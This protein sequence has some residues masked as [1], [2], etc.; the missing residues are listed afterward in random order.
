[1]NE[2]S[3]LNATGSFTDNPGAGSGNWNVRVT[4]GDN[5]GQ[6]NLPP[7]SSPGS[8]TLNHVYRDNGVYTVTVT[9]QDPNFL[10]SEPVSTQV[11]VNNVAPAINLQATAGPINESNFQNLNVNNATITDPGANDYP[12]S[13]GGLNP[14]PGRWR[15]G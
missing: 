8:F 10:M 4:Y 9:V 7:M 15:D 14:Q 1:M 2:G 6:F 12:G 13:N 5:T 3:S 11:A